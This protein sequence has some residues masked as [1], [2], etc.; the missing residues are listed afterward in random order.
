MG[1]KAFTGSDYNLQTPRLPTHVYERLRDRFQLLLRPLYQHVAI[2]VPAPEKE[3]HGDI[4]IL[5]AEPRN[6]GK[7]GQIDRTV[8]QKVLGAS[9]TFKLPGS[10]ATSFAVRLPEDAAQDVVAFQGRRKVL[11]K[12]ECELGTRVTNGLSAQAIVSGFNDHEETKQTEPLYVQ[13][14]VHV[15]QSLQDFEWLLFQHSHG[16]LWNLLGTTIRPFGLT[17]NHHGLHVRIP[18]IEHLNRKKSLI[19]LT[20]SPEEVLQVLGYDAGT[21]KE[22]MDGEFGS[23]EEMYRFVAR[24]KFFRKRPYLRIMEGKGEG[25]SKANDR[26]RMDQREGFRNFVQEWVPKLADSDDDE[27]VENEGGRSLRREQELEKILDT[28]GKREEYDRRVEEWR[29]ARKALET[30]QMGRLDRKLEAA[31]LEEYVS[32]WVKWLEEDSRLENS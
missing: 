16:D 29:R 27:S 31:E 12:A 10:H 32:A 30:K 5:V 13:V 14:D 26:K 7:S 6:P 20:S 17:A 9:S 23:W 28:F 8:L 18:E 22:L 4:D 1:G 21:L 15:C 25:S 11:P 19:L 2:P 24:G 3:T